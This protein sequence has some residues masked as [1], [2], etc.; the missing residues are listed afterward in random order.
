MDRK[1]NLSQQAEPARVPAKSPPSKKFADGRKELL[2]TLAVI[3]LAPIVALILTAFVFQSYEVDGPSMEPTLA[4]DDRLIVNKVGRTWSGI[5]SSD[6]VPDR[7]EIVVFNQKSASVGGNSEE[8]QLIKRV[9][10]VPGDRVV[11]EGGKVTVYNDEHPR[12]FLVD[13]SGPQAG[14]VGYTDGSIEQTVEKGE[15]FVL[16]DNRKNSLDSR[17]FGT[18]DSEDIVG[19]LAMRIY[20]LDSIDK[21]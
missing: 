8:K 11:I 17:N 5:W 19:T 2:S 20:P 21:F 13:E 15:I 7:H 18:I 3:I 4:D 14:H 1:I 6:Y 12:G 10:G 9:I 16:G